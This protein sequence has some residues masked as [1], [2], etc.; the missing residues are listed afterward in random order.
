[1]KIDRKLILKKKIINSF[2]L[3]GLFIAE[4][5]NIYMFW[6]KNIYKDYIFRWELDSSL[7]IVPIEQII[8]KPTNMVT[9]NELIQVIFKEHFVFHASSFS[10][11]AFFGIG[12][13]DEIIFFVWRTIWCYSKWHFPPLEVQ[14]WFLKD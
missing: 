13:K 9:F 6:T 7:R 3:I 4:F 11:L 1:M 12:E 10:M 14:M 5:Q 8:S 2:N